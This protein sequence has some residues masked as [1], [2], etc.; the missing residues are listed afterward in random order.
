MSLEQKKT[1]VFADQGK[2]KRCFAL[3][4]YYCT[5]ENC[6]F[7]KSSKEYQLVSVKYPVRKGQRL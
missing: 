5:V 3:N 4:D 2:K 6:K 7:W 1:C